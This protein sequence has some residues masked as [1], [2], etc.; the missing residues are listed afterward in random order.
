[1]QK[2]W[3]SRRLSF[4]IAVASEN[5]K[6]KKHLLSDGKVFLPSSFGVSIR[7][8]ISVSFCIT[9]FCAQGMSQCKINL[10]AGMGRRQP[11]IFPLLS[12]APCMNVKLQRPNCS[13]A[14]ITN[15][16]VMTFDEERGK[17]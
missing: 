9:S 16:L 6:N 4:K 12:T 2:V 8:F 5:I 13:G 7:Y 1:M 15:Y 10:N 17:K 11:S 3:N 14:K